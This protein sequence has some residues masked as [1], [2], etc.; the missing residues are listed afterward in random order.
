LVVDVKAPNGTAV[1]T[2]PGRI[3][4]AHSQIDS[5]N[6]VKTFSSVEVPLGSS[7]NLVIGKGRKP[8]WESPEDVNLGSSI[9]AYNETGDIISISLGTFES[10][11][12]GE[13]AYNPAF[14]W[15][16]EG[17]IF[18]IN[19]PEPPTL[20]ARIVSDYEQGEF[21]SRDLSEGIIW[22]R[23]L[24]QLPT[25]TRFNISEAFQGFEITE[26]K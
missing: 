16:G 6:I 26:A 10:S 22:S 17:L 19:L 11:P 5:Q 23:R 14:F 24:G 1:V 25:D 18:E 9:E 13:P 8:V 20:V 4:F 2:Y 3:G 15:D 12:S 7:V 21:L